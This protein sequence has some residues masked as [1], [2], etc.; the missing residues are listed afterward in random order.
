V[1]PFSAY[2]ALLLASILPRV[3]SPLPET[4]GLG[5]PITAAGV[6]GV[7]MGVLFARSPPPRRERAINLGG[8][9]GFAIGSLAYV[10]ALLAQ[11]LSQ[12]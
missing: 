6:G 5:L 11:V 9:W 2:V 4:V 7:L 10:V 1:P 8:F 12:L 3:E